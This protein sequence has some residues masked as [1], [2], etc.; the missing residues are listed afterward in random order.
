MYFLYR[1]GCV[2][3]VLLFGRGDR[4]LERYYD[5]CCQTI[6]GLGNQLFQYAMARLLLIYTESLMWYIK[7]KG[8]W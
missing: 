5:D 7:Y 4:F 3:T 2:L 1:I 8:A 6:G